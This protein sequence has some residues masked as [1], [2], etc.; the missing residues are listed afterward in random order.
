M[1]T[2]P[3]RVQCTLPNASHSIGG[4]LF[5][6]VPNDDPT[7]TPVMVSEPVDA[8]VSDRFLRTPGFA[9]SEHDGEVLKAVDEEIAA[10]RAAA[11]AAQ[12]AAAGSPL[13]QQLVEA[14]R[15]NEALAL[16]LKTTRDQLAESQ[17]THVPADQRVTALTAEVERLQRET[18]DLREANA[19]LAA[20]KPA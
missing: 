17:R 6:R 5:G 12:V 11:G 3:I 10:H 9:Q 4:T 20:E 1:A 16:E 7:I 13:Q 14:Q 15:A 8:A 19:A 18:Q 2:K